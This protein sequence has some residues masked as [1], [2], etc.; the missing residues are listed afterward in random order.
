MESSFEELG[1][2]KYSIALEIP[3]EEI[4]PTYDAVYKELKRTRLNGFRPGKYPKG[5]LDKRFT[6]AMQKEAVDRVIPAFMENA[7]KNHSLKPVTVPVIKQM[8]FDIKSPL[9]ATLHFEIAP[10]LPKLDYGKILLTRKEVEKVKDDEINDELES[11]IQSQ[12][13]LEPKSGND[14][15]VEKDDWVLIDYSGTIEGKEFTGSIAK[16]LQFKIGGSEYKEFHEALIGMHIGEDKEAVIEL[17]E[18]FDEKKGEKADFRIKLIAILTAK[19]PEMDEGYF[20]KFGVANE[21]ELKEKIFENIENRKKSELQSEYRMQVGSQLTGLYDDFIL[22]EEL[23]KLGNERVDTELEEAS[24]KKEITDEE[25]DKKRQEGY[26]NARMDLRMK[27]ILDSVREH[28]KLNFDEKEA[29]GEFFNLA[30][31]TGQN[32]D[33]LIQ[34]PFGRNMYQRIFIRKQGDATLDRIVARVFGDPIEET[35]IAE[36]HVHDEHCDHDH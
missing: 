5:W 4:K 1:D 33:E 34:T 32:P 8:D 14:L 26:E 12:A 20:Q 36:D 30:Q 6:S 23:V 31:I 22:P 9:S 17:S 18:R 11:L 29:T 10:N 25:R 7:L 24:S 19:R 2:L 15:K 16:E 27:F 28:E 21:K 35:T 3:L 13:S